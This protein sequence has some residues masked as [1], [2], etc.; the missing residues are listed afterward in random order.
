MTI[1]YIFGEIEYDFCLKSR[2]HR[3]QWFI[4]MNP[5][6]AETNAAIISDFDHGDDDDDDATHIKYVWIFCVFQNTSNNHKA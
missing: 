5:F 6:C 1:Q 4:I 3:I 2:V